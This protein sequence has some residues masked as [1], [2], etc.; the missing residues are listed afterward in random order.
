MKTR[1]AVLIACAVIG[2]GIVL[3]L[4]G[5]TMEGFNLKNIG[6]GNAKQKSYSF[7]EPFTNVE[8]GAISCD[9]AFVKTNENEARIESIHGENI[10]ETAEVK[11]GV[12][13]LTQKQHKKLTGLFNFN[14]NTVDKV[15]VYLPQS[16][17][18]SLSIS[19]AS[20]DISV[21][22]DFTFKSVNAATASGQIGI[23]AHCDEI[24][25][26]AV[27]GDVTLGGDSAQTV[28]IATSSGVVELNSIRISGSLNIKTVSGD[29]EL[30]HSDAG[31][32][33]IDTTSGEIQGVL[34]SGKTFSVKTTSG[35]VRVPA[36]TPG[37]GS[38]DIHTVSGDVEL[39][40]AGIL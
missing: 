15:T 9:V 36:N 26:A 16:E 10:E 38:C 2:V 32:I 28:K 34:L 27:S 3:C 4:A 24:N 25:A 18:D 37:A 22:S 11:G 1:N 29:I 33:N 20:G 5:F 6:S 8:I 19:T 14:L 31:E 39:S 23:L 17:Y 7:S 35:T 40:V 13:K 30:D 21:P 12:L